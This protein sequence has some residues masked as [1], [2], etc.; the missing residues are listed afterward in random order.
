MSVRCVRGATCLSRDDRVEMVEAVAELVTT[1]LERNELTSEDV[2]SAIFT[3]TPDLVAAF[4]AAA[5]REVPGFSQVPLI[6]ASEIDVAGALPSTVR[7]MMH[8][9][10]PKSRAEVR[11]VYL[12]GAEVLRQ[13]LPV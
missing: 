11:H 7:V 10:T 5:A 2:I 3:S 1:M 9:E 8:V 13:D 6:C 4:P 12:R